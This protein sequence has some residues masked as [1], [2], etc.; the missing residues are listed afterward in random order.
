ME[1]PPTRQTSIEAPPAPKEAFRA[2]DDA[3]SHPLI[4]VAAD[5]P[6]PAPPLSAW[7]VPR[8]S[9]R[10]EW[11]I[12]SVAA[13]S[14]AYAFYWLFWR[15][16][17]TLNWQ[18]AAFALVLVLAETLRVIYTTLF[19]ITVWKLTHHD[20]PPPPAGLKVDVFITCFDEPLQLLRRTAVGAKAIS[21]PH[22]TYIL[23][24]GKSEAVRAMAEE[25]GVG[26]IRREG[27]E[28][29]KAGNL[30]NAIRVTGGEFI[31]QLDADHVP[32][33]NILDRLLGY[34]N[35][36]KVGFVQSPQD[37]Y[38]TDS[39]T[40]IVNDEGHRLWEENRIFFSLVQAGKDTWESSFFC[41]T[42]GVLRRSALDS[43]GGFS[44]NSVTED[45]ETSLVL[46]GAGWKSRY[47]GETLAYGLAPASASQYHVQRMRWGTGS[48]Q[49][50]RKMNPLTYPGLNKKQR[51]QY[52]A[53]TI[54]YA[55]G[56]QKA[57]FYL[58]PI[59]FFFTGW[60]PIAV[61][62]REFLIR[63][64]P[65]M[66][67]TLLA[68]ELLARGTGWLV[69]S[70]RY[71][72][73]R[74][75]TNILSLSGFF[76]TRPIKF[77][78]TPKGVTDVPFS[79][80]APQLTLA[81]LSVVSVAWATVAA[82]FGWINYRGLASA[83]IW[84]N[85]IWLLWNMYFAVSV[86]RQSVRSKQQRHDFRFV[87]SLP[88]QIDFAAGDEANVSPDRKPAMTE[89][90]NPTGLSF[91]SVYRVAPGTRVRIPLRLASGSF[92]A[93]GEIVH[94]TRRKSRHGETF[95][96]GVQFRD[97]PNATRNAIE[98]HCTHHSVPFWRTRYRQSV[99]VFAH[100]FE[101]LADL[102]FGRRRS[103]KLPVIV[104]VCNADGTH[105]EPELGML[106][107][108]SDAGARLIL[109]SPIAPGSKVTYD[110]PGTD[111]AGRGTVVFNRTFES[112]TDVR[113]AVGV[114]CDR[115]VKS[116]WPSSWRRL[117]AALE[118]THA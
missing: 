32:L 2:V 104:R 47:H 78:V 118:T 62:E 80:Y 102:R 43:I 23:D 48:T 33:P 94:V 112:P 92:T 73:A 56:L 115:D 41:G 86:V 36:P 85:G 97:L 19:S 93:E 106:E 22:A 83:A 16:T 107:E 29:A 6:Q 90:L 24:D 5:V 76:R 25:I 89:D 38:N 27:N 74:F 95:I 99:P 1:A 37:F 103:V 13:A 51:L 4:S 53:A 57:V 81:V 52:F 55:S 65:Y 54:D 12:R 8:L 40:H 42:C 44:T 17:S 31:L 58:A 21:Y 35:D 84:V 20:P 49:I 61:N 59:V 96:H 15:W 82:H 50:L 63:L 18:V 66:V 26:Y 101:R 70:E 105:C 88:I 10:H 71:G 68:F 113:F 45:M 108:V 75:F 14:L 3:V 46:H 64:I 111:V 110:V 117:F 9:R 69:H 116:T 72:M 87:E 77:A 98:V 79:T 67:L 34:F 100:A 11:L 39:F 91:R 30:N 109:E 60:L 28:H 114:K 7:S